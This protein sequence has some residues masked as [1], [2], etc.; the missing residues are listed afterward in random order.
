MMLSEHFSL[1]EMLATQQRGIDNT[2][3]NAAIEANL[4]RTAQLLE[5]IRA[6]LNVPII[7]TSGYRCPQLNRAVGGSVNSA[8]MQGLAADF[9]VPRYGVPFDVCEAIRPHI[10]SLDIDQLIYEGGWT[11]IGLSVTAPRHDLLTWFG[12]NDYRAGILPRR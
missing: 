3:Q 5:R 10:I 2:P 1:D 6:V 8:H 12:G 7:I 4:T 9:I 11:H